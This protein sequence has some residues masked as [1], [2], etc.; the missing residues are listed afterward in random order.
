LGVTATAVAGSLLLPGGTA[1]APAE[2]VADEEVSAAVLGGLDAIGGASVPTG[3]A[4]VAL[5]TRRTLGTATW[6]ASYGLL[7]QGWTTPFGVDSHVLQL[8]TNTPGVLQ[9]GGVAQLR[10]SASQGWVEASLGLSASVVLP[11]DVRLWVQGGA[12]GRGE[13]TRAGLGLGATAVASRVL[14]PRAGVSLRVDG[15]AWRSDEPVPSLF[16]VDAAVW[17][18]PLPRWSGWADLG[19]SQVGGDPDTPDWAGLP[20]GGGHYTRAVGS[21]SVEVVRGLRL[22]ADVRIED[23]LGTAGD[24]RVRALVGVTG[25]LGRLRGPGATLLA[26]GAVWFEV[27]V[28][29]ATEVLLVG[30]FNGWQPVPLVQTGPGRWSVQVELP[31]GEHEFL[32]LVDGDPYVPPD[33]P[34]LRPDGFGGANAVLVVG[35]TPG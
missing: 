3:D 5:G 28:P 23:R 12:T 2:T 27:T 7:L 19:W 13:A 10:A 24:T 20:G 1:A 21:V 14:S 6:R 29:G 15:R 8:A 11:G 30:A 4:R 31:P 34:L 9:P 17:W 18:A 35:A 22:M 32:Y 26:P 33:A 16:D 25:R